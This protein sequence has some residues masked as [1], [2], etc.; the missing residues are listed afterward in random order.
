MREDVQESTKDRILDAAER[1]F[2]EHG[3][4]GTSLR[5]VIAKAGVN[6]AAVH[7]HF[8]SKEALLDAVVG[9][10]A[11][12]VNAERLTLLSDCERASG[13]KPSLE[14]VLEAFLAPAFRLSKDPMRGQTMFPRLM[15][16]LHSEGGDVTRNVLQTHFGEVLPRFICAVH[17]A[18][19]ELPVSELFWRWHFSI[20]A[21]AHSLS[22]ATEELQRMTEGLLSLDDAEITLERI[23]LFLAAGFRAPTTTRSTG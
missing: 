9:R 10:R 2:A 15:A 8:G 11:T 23:V 22:V 13:G 16:R 4:E 12:P 1:L 21:M 5:R 6:L 14:M 17:D 18:L 3:Y 19:P 7:Y 20:G